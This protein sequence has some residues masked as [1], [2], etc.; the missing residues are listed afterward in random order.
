MNKSPTTQ[1][2]FRKQKWNGSSCT[3]N[4]GSY[5][6]VSSLFFVSLFACFLELKSASNIAI[7]QLLFFAL[8]LVVGV[9]RYIDV[10][11]RSYNVYNVINFVDTNC[12]CW[13][14]QVIA[15]EYVGLSPKGS[16]IGSQIQSFLEKAA[17]GIVA[18]GK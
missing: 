1:L 18:G 17:E 15:L 10:E 13:C 16:Q 11:N 3:S 7:Q 14:E 4:L 5:S 2:K 8:R 6:L 12:C 9:K